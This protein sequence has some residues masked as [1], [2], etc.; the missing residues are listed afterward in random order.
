MV[1][2]DIRDAKIMKG[3]TATPLGNE[4]KVN[5]TV[6]GVTGKQHSPV[7]VLYT[8]ERKHTAWHGVAI[9]CRGLSSNVSFTSPIHAQ[10]YSSCHLHKIFPRT[11]AHAILRHPSSRPFPGKG[12]SAWDDNQSMSRVGY[13]D[14]RQKHVESLFP[15]FMQG[16]QA[17]RRVSKLKEFC[18]RDH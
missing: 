14:T 2:T 16:T 18:S 1:I 12:V 3:C 9:P 6:N 13:H 7:R 8:K 4:T 10:V 11:T 5:H 17:E 15:R